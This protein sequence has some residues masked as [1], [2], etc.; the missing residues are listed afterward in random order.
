M[1]ML[2]LAGIRI[3]STMHRKK[4]FSRGV[5]SSIPKRKAG[6]G[7]S[8]GLSAPYLIGKNQQKN[9]DLVHFFAQ[10]GE[11]V[12]AQFGRQRGDADG[13]GSSN[14]RTIRFHETD[15]IRANTQMLLEFSFNCRIQPI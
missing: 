11:N 14:C 2:P 6:L 4:D 10:E 5:S 8:G 13:P 1:I 3:Y 9:S 12:L 7:L 15:A